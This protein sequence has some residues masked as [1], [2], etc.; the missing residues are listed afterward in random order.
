MGGWI[1]TYAVNPS[2][3]RRTET[4]PPGG[5]AGLLW[6]SWK[7]REKGGRWMEMGEEEEEIVTVFFLGALRTNWVAGAGRTW[8]L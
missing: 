4:K 7:E 6:V 2:H 5:R 1:G 3:S 8:K